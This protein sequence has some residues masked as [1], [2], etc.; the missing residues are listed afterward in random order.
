M[1]SILSPVSRRTSSIG[2]PLYAPLLTL[3]LQAV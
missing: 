3:G 2:L 1:V